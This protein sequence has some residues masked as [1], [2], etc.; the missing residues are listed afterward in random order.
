MVRIWADVAGKGRIRTYFL[1][2]DIMADSANERLPR[3]TGQAPHA[4]AAN[5][6]ANVG[7]ASMALDSLGAGG[8][9]IP[10]G[11]EDAK[12]PVTPG[13]ADAAGGAP[14]T[15]ELTVEVEL[16]PGTTN[17]GSAL[18]DNMAGYLA[19]T[20]GS[21]TPSDTGL[22]A[23]LRQYAVTEARPV[24]TTEQVQADEAR[25]ADL[26][27]AAALG[28][29]SQ[30]Q[31][32]A[33]ERLPSLSSFVRLRFPSSTAPAEVTAALKQLPEVTQA[34][35][36]PRA[37]PP[38]TGLSAPTDPLVGTDDGP[39]AADPNTNLEPQW[40]LHRTRV[41]QAWRY[42]RGA[43]VVIADIDWGFRTTHQEFQN[44]TERTYNAVD[45]GSV[46][47]H[48]DTAA[49]GTA[50]LGIAGA[51]AN[52]LGVA[53][54]APEATLWAIQGDSAPNPR[55][56]EEP[57]AEAI[58]FVR[59]ADASTRRKVIILEVQTS[60][61]GNYEQ[62]PSVHRAVRAA[63]ADDCVVCVAAG[64]GNRPADRT[65]GG[66]PFDPTGSILV[67]ATAYDE[68]LN[69]R[70]WFS[71]YGS[72]VVVSAPGDP[73]H[74]VTCGQSADNAYRNAFGGTSGATPKVA[75]TV[76]LMLSVNPLL[77]HDDIREVLAGT[78]SPV[79]EDPGRPIGA[80]L[81]AEAAV[82]EALRRRSETLP[83]ESPPRPD[84]HP[85]PEG[86]ATKSLH[87]VR[88]RMSQMVLPQEPDGPISWDA[89]FDAEAQA[90]A[91]AVPPGEQPPAAGDKT[92]RLFRETAEGTLT[93]S[94][95][96][97]IVAQAIQMLDNFY[98]HRPLKE[99]IYAVRPIQRLRVLQRRLQQESNI[100]VAELDELTFHN[101]LTQIFDSVRDLHTRYQLP[102][103][104]RDYIAYLPFEVASF[105]E[106][107][108]RRY[109]VT[110][111]VPGY[112]FAAADFAPGAELFYWNGM[113][114]ERATRVNADQ[115]AG[116]NEAARHA[117]GVNA[118]TIRPMNT[119]LPPDADFVD[120]EYLPLGV[121]A[122]DPAARRS[123]RQ[124]WFVRYAPT[125]V[126]GVAPLASAPAATGG[127]QQPT[128]GLPP[129]ISFAA[130]SS[131]DMTR[132]ST[133]RSSDLLFGDS[134]SSAVPASLPA[135]TPAAAGEGASRPALA[136][137][138]TLGVDIA[139]DAVREARQL[140]F[141]STALRK[142]Q[143]ANVGDEV[144]GT[145][146]SASP[147]SVNDTVTGQEI[148]VKVPW[149]AAFR[150]STVHIDGAVCGHIQIRTFYVEDADGFLQEF[151]RL[152]EEMPESG[153]ILDVR[154]NGGG[155]IRAAERLLQTLS[156]AEIEPERMQFIVT[157]GTVE[158]SRNN[159]STSQVPL[160][161][162]RPSLEEA[163]ETGSV[164]SHAFPLTS[165][166]SC[167]TIGQR[168]YGPVVL[169]VDGNCY[170][171]TDIFAAGFQDH[172]IGK[173]LGVG[174]NTGAGG[175]NV[176][177]HWLLNEVLPPGWGLKSLPNQ[178]GMR[179]A[180]RQCLR[181]GPR[182]GALLE[183]F[184][185]TPDAVHQS[186]REDLMQGDKQLLA[187]ALELLASESV[188]GIEV[189]IGPLEAGNPNMR[190]ITIK[191]K[192]LKRLDFFI[193]DR[194]QA[195]RDLDMNAAGEATLKPSIRTGA[196]LRLAGYA[197]AS[198]TAPAALYRGQV[199]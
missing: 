76:A 139:A 41:P 161:L 103:P 125:T 79:T 154:G 28:A 12:T 20:G 133:A 89:V 149:N 166:E 17:I 78:G 131:I 15:E 108:Y 1:G 129:A 175:A 104:Y 191:T 21:T 60:V 3:K 51:R 116:S 156:P 169:I 100:P 109:L 57:W 37:A 90:D 86:P 42:A 120:L 170:S 132:E 27:A 107:G 106:G 10:T 45:G 26:R 9:F 157:A 153:L 199:A 64:N 168:Y 72:R 4:G 31:V 167:N 155:N 73:L 113:A 55:V 38:D 47:T 117:R 101:T 2:R 85:A 178:A 177:E 56:F 114:I 98:V 18:I 162:W 164:Y 193:D 158:L 124:Q 16:A 66:D 14:S 190:Q 84:G 140:I 121:D 146:A 111:V 165:K 33:L 187:K 179:V 186:T 134:T 110:R 97:L 80:F 82:A 95:R 102:R 148:A 119:T 151:L 63:I 180:I 126:G 5:P 75:G 13:G 94:D 112:A 24:F 46:V 192:G 184:G 81:N 135:V 83:A 144:Y 152:L 196:K 43:N 6:P 91:A 160:D 197:A 93:Q 8:P 7:D 48:G 142:A 147:A 59:R 49:H 173:I 172:Q 19:G 188:R 22:S 141:E 185:V 70:A 183:D 69:K 174:T 40:Y 136:L 32:S 65:D 71:N 138:A 67:G 34:V 181:V 143:C 92:L 36:V 62:I 194:P 171:A 35:V 25:T 137:A 130:Q 58:D 61:G 11:V 68:K 50:V 87:G 53:G 115:T 118:L 96:I 52:N 29:A 163:V 44:A 74:D 23:I 150:A 182:T 128:S 77:S 198:D 122:N 105:Y 189:T 127:A 176:W 30:D 39:I 88:R 159:P 145:R 99:A 195:T 54:Y 123:M